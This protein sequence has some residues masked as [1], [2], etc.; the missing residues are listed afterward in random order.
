[1]NAIKLNKIE[2][3]ALT[4]DEKMTLRGGTSGSCGCACCYEGQLG[5]ASE[6]ANCVANYQ[7]GGRY[8]KCDKIKSIIIY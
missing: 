2:N 4:N 7:L 6:S 3:N 8:S 1:M 5:G